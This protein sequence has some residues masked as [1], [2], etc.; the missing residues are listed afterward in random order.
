MNDY[1]TDKA[2]YTFRV[3]VPKPYVAAANGVLTATEDKGT[4]QTFV[5]EMKQP[6]ASYL[7]AVTIADYV[8]ED[9]RV[10]ERSAHPQ[11]LRRRVWPADART[12]SPARERCST[13]S[14]S[15]SVR[16][17]STVYGVVVPDAETG[18]AMENQTLSL[19]GRDVL[20]NG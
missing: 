14:P 13:T 16:I 17:P 20:E 8:L 4:D 12:P 10:A 6:Q 9:E 11:L 3:T 18:A 1:P 15:C 5:W 19:F 7:A 2:T